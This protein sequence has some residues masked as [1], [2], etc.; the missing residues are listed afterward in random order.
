MW[1]PGFNLQHHPLPTPDTA[2]GDYVTRSYRVPNDPI[3]LGL[4]NGVIS[5]LFY[6]EFWVQEGTATPEEVTQEFQEM[7]VAPEPTPPSEVSMLGAIVPFGTETIPEGWLICNGS[8]FQE[9]DYPALYAI[10]PADRK[11]GGEGWLWDL[12]A[13]FVV[14]AGTIPGWEQYYLGDEGGSDEVA[15]TIDE[16][17]AHTHTY[18]Y[19]EYPGSPQAQVVDATN[20]FHNPVETSSTGGDEPHENRPPYIGLIWAVCAIE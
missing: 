3:W 11:S 6:E 20:Y 10:W 15:L 7:Y 17:P 4:L 8:T 5:L 18:E 2:P 14:G 9:V 1:L 13:K 12:R 16:M 19:R